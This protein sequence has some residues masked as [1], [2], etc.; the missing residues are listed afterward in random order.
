[1][2]FLFYTWNNVKGKF[3]RK[4][5]V[6]HLHVLQSMRF[7]HTHTLNMFNSFGKKQT[8]KEQQK[9]NLR[10]SYLLLKVKLLHY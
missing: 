4:K 7:I 10:I 2:N 5:S 8:N 9:Q 3:A 6:H 1:M